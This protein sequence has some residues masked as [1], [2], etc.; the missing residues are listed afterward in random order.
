[1]NPLFQALRTSILCTLISGCA[2]LHS[3][4][5]GD[6]DSQ[7]VLQGKPFEI[8]V[9]ELGLST[10]DVVA[11]GQALAKSSG[12]SDEVGTIGDIIE[13]FQMGPRTGNPTF[14]DKY[15]DDIRNILLQECPSGRITGLM[16][17]RETA[18]YPVVSGEIVRVVGHCIKD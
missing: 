4:Q 3:V 1:M 5:L 17:V 2:V 7:T 6:I 14:T 12:K 13:L 10:E 15:T 9:S 11:I 18:Q 8:K 16:A